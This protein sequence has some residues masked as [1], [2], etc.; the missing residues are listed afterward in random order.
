MYEDRYWPYE[1]LKISFGRYLTV[2]HQDKLLSDYAKG[3]SGPRDET[4]LKD[5][6]PPAWWAE[7]WYK[8]EKQHKDALG[9]FTLPNSGVVGNINATTGDLTLQG[10][11]GNMVISNLD[12]ITLISE[13]M[14]GKPSVSPPG[15][16]GNPTA[17]VAAYEFSA[18]LKE[19]HDR[20]WDTIEAWAK[21]SAKAYP[22]G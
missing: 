9:N 17:G 19:Q 4:G 22:K 14:K 2:L 1:L 15:T 11:M 18:Q 6:G 3:F 21:A 8:L 13:A 10:Q 12:L 20:N 16:P 5:A 7:Q